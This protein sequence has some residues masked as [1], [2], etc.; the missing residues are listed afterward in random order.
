MTSI[1]KV[2]NIQYTD[3]DAALTIADGGGVTAAT[4]LAVTG[5]LTTTGAFTSKGIDDNADATAI[6]I[7]SGARVS[8][9]Y[10]PMFRGKDFVAGVATN[11]TTGY[12]ANNNHYKPLSIELNQGNCFDNTNGIFTVPTSG[13]YFCHITW[14]RTS[15]NWIG[16]SLVKNTTLIRLMWMA[17]SSRT[18]ASWDTRELICLVS[19]VATDKLYFCYANAYTAPANNN[20]TD[21]NIFKVA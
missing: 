8:M 11:G 3:G 16:V 21:M 9:P 20:N 1:I 7:D 2:Q 18:S 12:S 5:A 14:A 19:A 10:Q 4:T 6:T 15:D 17:V 13:I